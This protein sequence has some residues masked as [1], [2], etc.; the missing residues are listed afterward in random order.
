METRLDWG[1]RKGM[2][3]GKDKMKQLQ[4][5]L[6]TFTTIHYKLD[7]FPASTCPSGTEAWPPFTLNG[8]TSEH[9][10]LWRIAQQEVSLEALRNDHSWPRLLLH[11]HGKCDTLYICEVVH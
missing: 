1:I 4:Q 10:L 7:S 11:A 5:L 6:R 9:F 8:G 2:E 3:T